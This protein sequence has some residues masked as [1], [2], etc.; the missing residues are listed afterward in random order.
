M[1]WDRLEARNTQTSS[2]RYVHKSYSLHL[3]DR[4]I[5]RPHNTR[6]HKQMVTLPRVD[7]RSLT[8]LYLYAWNP[9]TCAWWD[10]VMELP[11]L[12]MYLPFSCYLL[13]GTTYKTLPA[14]V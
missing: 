6:S 9:R 3:L 11:T 8:L 10:D 1:R 7:G 4:E 13:P 14:I 5:C 12:G 2:L